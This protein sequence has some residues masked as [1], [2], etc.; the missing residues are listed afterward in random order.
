MQAPCTISRGGRT[1]YRGVLGVSKIQRAARSKVEKGNRGFLLTL[2]AGQGVE[3]AR[4][5]SVTVEIANRP[6]P[7]A[8]PLTAFRLAQTILQFV[9]PTPIPERK[10]HG[11]EA[12]RAQQLGDGGQHFGR[13]QG[14]VVVAHNRPKRAFLSV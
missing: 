8:P 10:L 9:G 7:A 6:I 14:F 5:A 1:S 13:G 3:A 4:V 2:I 12:E 11:A